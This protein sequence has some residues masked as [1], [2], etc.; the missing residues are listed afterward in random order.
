MWRLGRLT[1]CTDRKRVFTCAPASALPD[2]REEALNAWQDA[3]PLLA[4]LGES[5]CHVDDVGFESRCQLCSFSLRIAWGGSAGK[6]ARRGARSLGTD[7]A[8]VRKPQ[9]HAVAHSDALTQSYGLPLLAVCPHA[10]DSWHCICL[11]CG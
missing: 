8:R 4:L 5:L 10:L 1:A 3:D 6:N 7:L 2:L 9:L 11:T